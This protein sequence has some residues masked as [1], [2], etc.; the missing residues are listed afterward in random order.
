MSQTT[1]AEALRKLLGIT[2]APVMLRINIYYGSSKSKLTAYR[3]P[4]EPMTRLEYEDCP[5][6]T[7]FE[8]DTV[9]RQVGMTLDDRPHKQGMAYDYYLKYIDAPPE[10]QGPA[11]YGLESASQDEINR[12]SQLRYDEW[13]FSLGQ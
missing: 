13:R 9:L 5:E 2:R 11:P 10:G 3:V 6:F 8:F 12:R 7:T 4:G 1:G